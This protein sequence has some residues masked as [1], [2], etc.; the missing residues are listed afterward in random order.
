[1]TFASPVRFDLGDA[2]AAHGHLYNV[3]V[4]NGDEWVPHGQLAVLSDAITING[5]HVHTIGYHGANHALT[6]RG[7]TEDPSFQARLNLTDDGSAFV[8]TVTT[9]QGTQGIRGTELEQV[10]TT[11]RHLK[12]DKEAP[13][14]PWDDFTIKTEWVDGELKVTYLLG[15]DDLSNRVR[16]TKV[17]RQKGETTLEMVPELVPPFTAN[18]FTIVL[19]SGSRTF[20]GIYTDDDSNDWNWTGET[21][22]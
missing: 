7:T 1:M 12:S 11:K 18:A 10:Y 19:A 6:L 15:T 2:R 8:G 5:A 21:A 14:R 4:H 3:E 13:F 20:D 9:S 17:D 16:V 22:P